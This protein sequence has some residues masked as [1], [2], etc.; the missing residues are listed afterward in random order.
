MV[1][2]RVEDAFPPRPRENTPWLIADDLNKMNAFRKALQSHKQSVRGSKSCLGGH[3]PAAIAALAL[4]ERW[5][6]AQLTRS[7]SDLSDLP[8]LSDLS[9]LYLT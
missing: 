9:G 3:A 4:P 8:D 2:A 6:G 5:T 1:S 7:I